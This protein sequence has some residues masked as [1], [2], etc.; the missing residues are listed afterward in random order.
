MGVKR[1]FMNLK[2]DVTLLPEA[3]YTWKHSHPSVFILSVHGFLKPFH[4]HQIKKLC[5]RILSEEE[6]EP[7]KGDLIKLTLILYGK[8]FR[9][10]GHLSKINEGDIT[11]ANQMCI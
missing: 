4:T 2:N 9:N 10:K 8:T 3:K 1:P 11:K 6:E 5:C 7:I